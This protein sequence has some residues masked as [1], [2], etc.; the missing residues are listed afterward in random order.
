MKNCCQPK[1]VFLLQCSKDICQERM[2]QLGEGHAGYLPSTLLSK[3][4]KMF[5][6]RCVSLLPYLRKACSLHEICTE[7]TFETACQQICKVVEPTI[8][9]CRNGLSEASKEQQKAIEEEL[10]NSQGFKLLDVEV[11]RES[12]EKR[13]TE[14][15]KCLKM[16]KHPSDPKPSHVV[17]MLKRCI[18]NGGCD[19][20]F[21][22]VNFPLS[23]E[24]ANFFESQCAKISAIVYTSAN[25]GEKCVE[26]P[27]NM[28]V[29]NLDAVFQKDFR[30]KT[31]REWDAEQFSAFL[32]QKID[33]AVVVGRSLSGKSEV[34]KEL[35]S[36]VRGKV[37]NMANISAA[38]AKTLGTE[39]EPF[40]GEVP[41]DKVEQAVLQ[42]IEA[43]RARGDRFTY[44]F[45]GFI[46][47]KACDF[48]EFAQGQF[49]PC[50]FWV[51]CACETKCI[52]ER[53]KKKNETEE[54]G[55]DVAAELAEQLKSAE[56]CCKEFDTAIPNAKCRINVQTDVSMETLQGNL[57]GQFAAKVVIVNHEKRLSVDSQCANL[58]TKYNMLYLS[59]YQLIKIH[60]CG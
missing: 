6:E 59:V 11:L 28:A 15:G 35:C 13:C 41:C 18:F 22:L 3:K 60:I 37:I 57:R 31:M 9:H 23:P 33:W 16:H 44:I 4:I 2:I 12:E 46:H 56:A 38:V 32:G 26:V 10:V 54:I 36:L 27:G 50:S 39:D 58:A 40:E 21:L 1:D 5:N 55:E 48:I 34:A 47:K 45:D 19:D 17:E 43:D 42:Q 49:G 29:A 14:L 24:Q 52:E 7:K 30:L 8:I 20:K 25:K 51:N 53:Y